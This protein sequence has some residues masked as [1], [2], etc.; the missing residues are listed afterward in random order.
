MK[1]GSEASAQ[2]VGGRSHSVLS[3][4]DGNEGPKEFGFFA[5]EDLPSHLNATIEFLSRRW[6]GG[7]FPK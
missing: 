2:S 3:G 1:M 6:R 7:W 4:S 5:C